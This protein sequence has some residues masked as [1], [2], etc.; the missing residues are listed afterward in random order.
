M[1]LQTGVPGFPDLGHATASQKFLQFIMIDSAWTRVHELCIS[2]P[3]VATRFIASGGGVVDVSG[4]FPPCPPLPPRPRSEPAR[5]PWCAVVVSGRLRAC[6]KALKVSGD[7]TMDKHRDQKSRVVE[8]HNTPAIYLAV[9]CHLMDRV[10]PQRRS[11]P[12]AAYH[13]REEPLPGHVARHCFSC[14]VVWHHHRAG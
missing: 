10:G 13:S 9:I 4:P 1:T 14:R 5:Q 11:L 12:E 2:S 3:S 7:N 6:P 8:A